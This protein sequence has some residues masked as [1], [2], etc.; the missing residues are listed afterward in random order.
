MLAR[1]ITYGATDIVLGI[2]GSASTDGGAGMVQALGGRLLDKRG[3]DL[4]QGG[5]A[6]Q[7]LASLDLTGLRQMVSKLRIVVASDV[8]NPLLGPRGAVAVLGPQK[9][10][11]PAEVAQLE[12]ALAVWAERVAEATGC[13]LA[14]RAGSGAAGAPASPHWP[15]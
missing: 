1:A 14:S 5:A 13:D 12:R 3:R 8:D 6:L 7:D 15:C 4:P 2:G 11:G 10:A 9:G